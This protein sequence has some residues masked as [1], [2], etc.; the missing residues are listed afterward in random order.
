VEN[1]IRPTALGKKNWL[2][3]G[4]AEA[5][6]RGAILYTIIDSCRY[7]A[8]DPYAYLRDVFT[9]LPSM[10]NWQVKDI[11]PEAWAKTRRSFAT[12]TAA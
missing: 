6:Q 10:I 7:R 8:I 12:A 2:F 1:A 3:L 4:D 11:T 5:G 9:R